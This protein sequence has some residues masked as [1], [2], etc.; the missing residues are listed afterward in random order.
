VK[1]YEVI[2]LLRAERD[3][4]A[5]YRRMMRDAP[6]GADQWYED[7]SAAIDSL[8]EMP[9]RCPLAPEASFFKQE[10]RHLILGSYRILF[11]VGERHV[12]VMTVRHSSRKPLRRPPR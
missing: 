3:M 5:A 9:E 10:V 4:E 2:T 8:G 12:R 1:Y 7:I 6:S 11:T